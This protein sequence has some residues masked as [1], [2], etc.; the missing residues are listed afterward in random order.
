[1]GFGGWCDANDHIGPDGSTYN[2]NGNL[3]YA[4]ARYG[5]QL[6]GDVMASMTANDPNWAASAQGSPYVGGCTYV[7]LQI[8]YDAAMFPNGVESEIRFD[9]NGKC[10]IY[11]PRT[12]T[13]G[14]TTNWALLVA[15]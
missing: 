13:H 3:V 1:V 8:S 7:Y 12:Q 14:F 10:N 4:E 2:F 9:V 6:P 15:D 5:D 11:D